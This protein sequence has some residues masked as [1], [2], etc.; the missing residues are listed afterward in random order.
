VMMWLVF[1]T[2]GSKPAVQVMRE[3]F[4]ENLHLMAEYASPWPRGKP[5]DLRKIRTLR[6]KISQNFLAVT[7][8]SDAVLFEIG[9][10]RDHSLAVRDQLHGWQPQLRSLFLMEIALLVYRLQVSPQDLPA[11]IL[12][13]AA[14]FDSE[15]GAL[16]EGIARAFQFKDTS[17]KP[18]NIQLAYA[19]LEQAILDAF[20]NQPPLR[21][22]A[23][24]AIASQIIEL[25]CRLLAEI[26]AA[27][28]SE[29]PTVRK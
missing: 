13:A 19:D 20:H 22:R 15:V 11:P 29:A 26:T 3:L 14:R 17:S 10:S 25:A 8:Q 28:F 9:R 18:D 7:L 16:L 5:P 23:V 4:A 1:E 12:R 24:L 2:L 21:S 6:E 27:P